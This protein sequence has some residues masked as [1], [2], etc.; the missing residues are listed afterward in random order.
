MTIR[1]HERYHQVV[2]RVENEQEIP[3]FIQTPTSLVIR[4]SC[5]SQAKN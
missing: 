1:F 3:L 2:K 4:Q 5:G